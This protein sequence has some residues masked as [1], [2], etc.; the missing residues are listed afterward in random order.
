MHS[1]R[2]YW[3][4]MFSLSESLFCTLQDCGVFCS[5]M[6]ILIL[7]ISEERHP[8]HGVD[9]DCETDAAQRSI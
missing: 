3:S 4:S 1:N 8:G 5:L 6:T 7:F 9:R 2:L